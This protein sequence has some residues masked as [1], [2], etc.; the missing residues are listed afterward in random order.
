MANRD[1]TNQLFS[2]EKMRKF[3]DAR[4]SFGATGAPTLDGANS[5]GVLS[6]TR[7][8]AGLYT[9]Q[10]G[11]SLGT[12][13]Q[14]D[15]Y[16]KLLHVKWT[17]SVSAITGV[18]AADRGVAVYRNDLLTGANL[19]APV[20]GATGD[21]STATSGGALSDS[22]TYYYV[23]TAVD[24]NGVESVA[25]SETSK[26]TGNSGSNVNTITATWTAV[27]GAQKYRVYRGTSAGAENVVYEVT[28]ATSYVDTGAASQASA[29][30]K[31]QARPPIAAASITLQLVNSAGA[32]TDPASGEACH[33]GFEFGDSGAA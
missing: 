26:A 21:Y 18:A 30:N 32:A 20:N 3:V 9:L 2:F 31:I 10:F 28:G 1:M 7:Q 5:K 17:P 6:I 24:Y 15:W 14:Y 12:L 25:S 19:A 8:S 16:A 22:T 23:V 33:L 4:I 11:V 27:A 29:A 13:S